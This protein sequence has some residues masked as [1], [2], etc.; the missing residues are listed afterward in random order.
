MIRRRYQRVPPPCN[1]VVTFTRKRFPHETLQQIAGRVGGRSVGRL[2]PRSLPLLKIMLLHH[3]QHR[4]AQWT[5]CAQ[6]TELLRALFLFRLHSTCI[7]TYRVSRKGKAIDRLH[8]SVRP[9]V[10]FHSYFLNRPTFNLDF[11]CGWIITIARLELKVKIIGQ[12]Q[13]GV[14]RVWAW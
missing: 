5:P 1:R 10:R 2:F 7:I 8:G 4:P 13:M 6:I 9:S 12:G 11:F 3:S 14:Q